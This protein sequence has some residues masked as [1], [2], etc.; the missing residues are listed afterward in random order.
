MADDFFVKVS[1]WSIGSYYTS[2]SFSLDGTTVAG[3]LAKKK[4]KVYPEGK[5]NFMETATGAVTSTFNDWRFVV[6]SPT[7]PDMAAVVGKDCIQ[8]VRRSSSGGNTWH[9]QGGMDEIMDEHHFVSCTFTSDGK[10]ITLR[11]SRGRLFEYNPVTTKSHKEPSGQRVTS[12]AYCPIEPNWRIVGRDTDSWYGSFQ[13]ESYAGKGSRFESLTGKDGPKALCYLEPVGLTA[14][15]A[16]A[17]SQD[18]KWIA[19]CDD[20]MDVCLW[21]TSVRTVPLHRL[22]PRDRSGPITNLIFVLD[23]TALLIH[24]GDRLSMWDIAGGV[25]VTNSG[26]PV[27]AKKVAWD[28]PRNRFA[29]VVDHELSL[30]EL[31]L[32]QKKL[33]GP[34]LRDQE[35]TLHHE[36]QMHRKPSISSDPMP[37]DQENSLHHERQMHRKPSISLTDQENPLHHERQMHQKPSISLGPTLPGQENPLH[38]ERPMHR[39]PSISSKLA[40][41]NITNSVVKT[42]PDP[43][44]VSN[45]F[46]IYRGVWNFDTP[47]VLQHAVVIKAVRPNFKAEERQNFEDVR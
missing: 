22:L 31:R 42:K 44:V 40:E 39:K 45:V 19:T 32:P 9:L 10:R 35:N 20:N 5:V 41:F 6:F 28:G 17:W 46:D 13:I 15:S 18:G 2:L 33:S 8:M 23:S 47:R 25:Y 7:D 4:S 34:T 36:R 27:E 16:C 12:I 1:S 29:I 38:H 30:Y 24:C 37:T 14:F 21:D 43:F 26:L 11:N 3:T